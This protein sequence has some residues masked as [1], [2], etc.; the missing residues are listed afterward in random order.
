M[1]PKKNKGGPPLVYSESLKI[2]VARDYLT[3]NLSYRQLA[4]KYQLKGLDVARWFVKWYNTRHG[5]ELCVSNGPPEQASSPPQEVKEL[6]KQL[7]NANLKIAALE[8][9][10]EMAEKDL[11][12]DIRK[13]PGTKQ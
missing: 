2:V 5:T 11:G 13:K 3:S 8:I 9:M 4:E 1:H 6:E 12:I 10:I 7:A